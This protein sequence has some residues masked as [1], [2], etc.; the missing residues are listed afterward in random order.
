MDI[1]IQPNAAEAAFSKLAFMSMARA[2]VFRLLAFAFVDPTHDFVEQ[3][4]SGSYISELHGYYSD[5]VS[6]YHVGV[7]ALEPLKTYHA[8]ISNSEHANLLRELKV[9]YCRLFLG[10]ESPAVQPYESSYDKKLKNDAK[11]LL[12]VSPIAMAVEKAYLEAGLV[13]QKELRESPDHFA[14]E[15]EFLYYLCKKESDAWAAGNHAG[16]KKWRR[17]QLAFLDGHLAKW[18]CEFC[19]AVKVKSTH[20]FFQAVGHFG[21][22]FIQLDGSDAIQTYKVPNMPTE[23]DEQEDQV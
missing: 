17:R 3:L 7:D 22:A 14:T 4:V 2:N 18:G 19:Q 15:M 11:P 16:A 9:E 21:E 13:M 1:Q 5:L 8:G 10:P 12:I 6:H 23:A 20:P